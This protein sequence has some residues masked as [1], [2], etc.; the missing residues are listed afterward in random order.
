M[1]MTVWSFGRQLHLRPYTGERLHDVMDFKN[2]QTAVVV[3]FYY[4][5]KELVFPFGRCED[6]KKNDL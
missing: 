4:P 5:D 3:G 1:C 2:N 6:G